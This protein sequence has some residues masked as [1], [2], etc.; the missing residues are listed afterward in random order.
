MEQPYQII[1]EHSLKKGFQPDFAGI[2]AT[3]LTGL[4][5]EYHNKEKA[6]QVFGESYQRYIHG[7]FLR[8][9]LRRF[10]NVVRKESFFPERYEPEDWVLQPH[11][12]EEEKEELEELKRENWLI[13][14]NLKSYPRTLAQYAAATRNLRELNALEDIGSHYYLLRERVF[15][16]IVS[17]PNF[18]QV[19][20]PLIYTPTGGMP[21]SRKRR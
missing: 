1:L 13:D 10:M 15:R 8:E 18:Q 5:L 7:P 21:D 17:N 20:G 19:K 14:P 2:V 9:Q 16:P 3:N 12:I 4:A 11:D 6:K